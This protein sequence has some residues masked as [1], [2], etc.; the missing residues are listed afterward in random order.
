MCAVASAPGGG[1]HPSLGEY[2]TGLGP[3]GGR[4]VPEGVHVDYPPFMLTIL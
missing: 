1:Q 3:R 2:V 4:A